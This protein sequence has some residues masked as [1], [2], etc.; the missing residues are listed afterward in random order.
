[1]SNETYSEQKQEVRYLLVIFYL[2]ESN[3]R[4]HSSSFEIRGLVETPAM[5]HMVPFV[6]LS[7]LLP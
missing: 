5:S 1:M 6:K 2:R 3:L 4:V 7:F